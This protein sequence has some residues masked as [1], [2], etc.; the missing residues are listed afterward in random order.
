[1]HSSLLPHHPPCRT[2]SP[3]RETDAKTAPRSCADACAP[4]EGD[5]NKA[6]G[7]DSRGASSV[8]TLNSSGQQHCGFSGQQQQCCA[9]DTR[10]LP[11]LTHQAMFPGLRMLL[12]CQAGQGDGKSVWK[13][14]SQ[15]P[16]VPGRL[17][18]NRET[19]KPWRAEQTKLQLLEGPGE[20]SKTPALHLFGLPSSC[21]HSRVG[22]SWWLCM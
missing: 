1:M 5:I 17:P 13:R 16:S 18:E 8:P 2:R 20:Q 14:I 6:L 4:V 11:Q 10:S 7:L 19:G 15:R 12:A 9:G 22:Q 21:C 3:A